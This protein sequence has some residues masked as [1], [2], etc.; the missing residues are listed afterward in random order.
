MNTFRA[1]LWKESRENLPRL[2]GLLAAYAFLTAIIAASRDLETVQFGVLVLTLLVPALVAFG[3]LS[4]ER[5]RHTHL[6]LRVLPV[7]PR[8]II[9]AKWFWGFLTALLPPLL[10][11]AGTSLLWHSG[12]G[13]RYALR[14]GP[15]LYQI[16]ATAALVYTWALLAGAAA[17]NQRQSLAAIALLLLA[18]F[19]ILNSDGFGG[20]PLFYVALPWFMAFGPEDFGGAI[21]P[22]A[23]A[24]TQACTFLILT[25]LAFLLWSRR[26]AALP[27]SRPAPDHPRSI[28]AAAQVRLRS[29]RFP[30]VAKAWREM[31]LTILL[32]A[33]VTI[34]LLPLGM[35]VSLHFVTG[36]DP[37]GMKWVISPND[38]VG[39]GYLATLVAA[40][41][42]GSR[43]GVAQAA[44]LEAFWLARPISAGRYFWQHAF[45]ELIAIII[46]LLCPILIVRISGHY[47]PAIAEVYFGPGLPGLGWIYLAAIPLIYFF[48]TLMGAVTRSRVVASAF[49]TAFAIGWT[50]LLAV[51][52]MRSYVLNDPHITAALFF[53]TSFLIILFA[54][55]ARLFF[56]FKPFSQQPANEAT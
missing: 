8:D 35:M 3:I 37:F 1:L 49:A 16:A 48:G 56:E 50:L 22:G 18:N 42:L 30:I 34:I 43:L 28:A 51:L 36:S 12:S 33:A 45:T 24:L 29:W 14:C 54:V 31:R 44:S 19:I 13:D 27:A 20:S 6:L 25:P 38:V 26:Y 39:Y 40:I 4:N 7:R 23:I 5:W 2:L 9:A 53:V 41:G 17:R 47:F 15:W 10:V 52:I 46:L 55:L 11:V 21:T 32:L